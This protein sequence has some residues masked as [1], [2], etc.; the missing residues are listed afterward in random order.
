MRVLVETK[1]NPIRPL[2]TRAFR[3]P[4]GLCDRRYRRDEP[5]HGRA[6]LR[7]HPFFCGAV[8]RSAAG[9]VE[10]V[11]G[12]VEPP[13]LRAGRT[14]PRLC[15][16]RSPRT[17]C[18]T[19]CRSAID[20]FATLQFGA[21][22]EGIPILPGV[23]VQFERCRLCRHW[24]RDPVTFVGQAGRFTHAGAVAANLPRGAYRPGR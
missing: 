19:L 4:L 23:N 21:G 10:P 17:R 13:R 22:P 24:G 12:V 2:D 6:H 3:D 20:R 16:G 7:R 15:A 8:T 14:F 5:R 11:D 9:V 1:L 18:S